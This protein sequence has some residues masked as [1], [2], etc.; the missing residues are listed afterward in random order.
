MLCNSKKGILVGSDLSSSAVQACQV[1]E[2]RQ[3]VLPVAVPSG[4]KHG[5]PVVGGS[6]CV[7]DLN[8]LR[9]LGLCGAP[10]R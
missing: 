1:T 4:Q 8:G 10:I 5:D 7:K 9:E 3:V 2:R 6:D